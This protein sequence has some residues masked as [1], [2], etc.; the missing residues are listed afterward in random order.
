VEVA[1]SPQNT[2]HSRFHWTASSVDALEP[3]LMAPLLQQQPARSV[4]PH[5]YFL[6]KMNP[7]LA[8]YP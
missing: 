7:F 3:R 8:Y 4:P 2:N 1:E 5:Q 6:K